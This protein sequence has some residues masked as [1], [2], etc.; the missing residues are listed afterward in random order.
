MKKGF[1]MSLPFMFV[2]AFAA[3]A[4]TDATVLWESKLETK[5]I[6]AVVS[7]QVHKDFPN[8]RITE[9]YSLP[10]HLYEQKWVL[11][12]QNPAPQNINYVE[13]QLNGKDMH[14]AAVYT[15]QG[16]LLNSREVLKHAALP[17]AVS[18]AIAAHYPGWTERRDKEVVKNGK[19]EI[20]R[21]IVFLKKGWREERVV[22]DPDGKVLHHIDV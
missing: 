11:V 8:A 19:H 17:P 20:T 1:L 5:K 7:E 2:G 15:P 6:P 10:A 14:Y 3:Q 9:T 18:Q 22:L 16:T 12:Q 4:Q 13:V 21:Y